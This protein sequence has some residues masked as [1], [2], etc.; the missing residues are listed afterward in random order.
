M[1]RGGL[2]GIVI[3]GHF[4][5]GVLELNFNFV[6]RYSP[7]ICKCDYGNTWIFDTVLFFCCF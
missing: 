5:Y 7:C 4:C 6:V 2:Y 1:G 3:A